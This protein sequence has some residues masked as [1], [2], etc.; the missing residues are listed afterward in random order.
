MSKVAAKPP[1]Q[2]QN[3]A[4]IFAAPNDLY[5][6]VCPFQSKT[7]KYRSSEGAIGAEQRANSY[8]GHGFYY[9]QRIQESARDDICLFFYQAF[10]NVVRQR[11]YIQIYSGASDSIY[12]LIVLCFCIVCQYLVRTT[13]KL[14]CTRLHCSMEH[15]FSSIIR[16]CV[17]C[18]AFGAVFSL[19]FLTS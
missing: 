8:N 15:L 17:M 6:L 4:V 3:N 16:L 10:F 7:E 12:K 14:R 1:D 18:L 2:N 5:R 19:A 9:I 13:L 11:V